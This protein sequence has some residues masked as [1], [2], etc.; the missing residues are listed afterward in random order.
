VNATQPEK[1]SRPRPSRR[2]HHRAARHFH[3]TCNIAW[4][5][6]FIVLEHVQRA[7]CDSERRR[8]VRIGI[9]REIFRNSSASERV[10]AVTLRIFL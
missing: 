4:G 8:H 3:A 5:R 1:K 2:P 7:L 6:E 10:L 9:S